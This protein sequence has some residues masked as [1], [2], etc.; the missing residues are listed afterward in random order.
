MLRIVFT[1]M[2]LLTIVYLSFYGMGSFVPS[3]WNLILMSA[4]KFLLISY[5]FMNLVRA[6]FFW[7]LIFSTLIF[8]YSFGIWYF[9]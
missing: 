4:I 6:H 5:V 9:T 8:V 2:I 1:Y 7:K 3:N